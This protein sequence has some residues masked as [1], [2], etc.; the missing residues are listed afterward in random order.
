MF[1]KDLIFK[2]RLFIVFEKSKKLSCLLGF[3]LP[4]ELL[5]PTWMKLTCKLYVWCH[6]VCTHIVDAIRKEAAIMREEWEKSVCKTDMASNNGTV[7]PTD[8][9]CFEML[10]MVSALSGSHV[11]R[12]YLAD[13][14]D[15]LA[16]LLSLLHT[17]SARVQRQVISSQR[18]KLL[19]LFNPCKGRK[20]WV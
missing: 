3:P 6:Q 5:L 2:T 16:N 10:S 4:I 11:G 7:T 18:T 1:V 13:Q 17:G 15:L 9:Y 8:S 19:L 14:H 20:S 12:S